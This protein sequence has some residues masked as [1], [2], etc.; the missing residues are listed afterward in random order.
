MIGW[1]NDTRGLAI[2]TLIREI[3]HGHR[4]QRDVVVNL[5]LRRGPVDARGRNDLAKFVRGC[6]F[7]PLTNGG[8]FLLKILF[9]GIEIVRAVENQ[10]VAD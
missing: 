5:K 6:V 2:E 4:M 3:A 9:T 10:L 1:S 8:E 7:V